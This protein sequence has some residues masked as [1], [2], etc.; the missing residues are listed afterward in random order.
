MKSL[1]IALET[2][3]VWVVTHRRG[4]PFPAPTV[5]SGLI[6]LYLIW[7]VIK[8]WAAA[9][10]HHSLCPSWD[11]GPQQAAQVETRSPVWTNTC[12]VQHS[13]WDCQSNCLAVWW[14]WKT[15]RG[16]TDGVYRLRFTSMKTNCGENLSSCITEVSGA[17]LRCCWLTSGV[18]FPSLLQIQHKCRQQE[19]LS[20]AKWSW[21]NITPHSAPCLGSRVGQW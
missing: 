19:H 6:S 3:P 10:C 2:E 9:S 15:K 1:P 13:L 21:E 16:I 18:S 20:C 17:E 4:A 12:D 14:I 11:T 7:L 5:C 8:S